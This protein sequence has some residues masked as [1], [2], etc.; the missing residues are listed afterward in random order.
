MTGFPGQAG[1]FGRYRILRRIGYGGM[2][3]VFEAAQDGLGRNVALKVLLPQLSDAPEFRARF[4][5]EARTLAALDSPHVIQVYEYGEEDGQLYIATQLVKGSDLQQL[6]ESKGP[7]TLVRS[8]E[9]VAQLASGLA[10]AHAAGLLH[11]DVKP[12][13]VL[14]RESLDDTH[15]YLCDFGI[16]RD[17]DDAHLTSTGVAGTV[18]Y[19]APE[20]HSGVEAT[21]ASDVYS[22][23]CVLW[24]MITGRAPYA[25]HSGVQLALA[26]MH[27]PLPALDDASA[28][29]TVVNRVL[30]RSM[31]KD[32]VDRYGSALEMRRDLQAALDV[33]KAQEA[34][35]NGEET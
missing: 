18:G 17:E 23:G 30:T 25:G 21:A 22:L 14:L 33:A 11:R 28:A 19:M 13:N 27:E 34:G 7:A 31:A 4:E 35:A 32:P 12:S 1:V 3:T 16:A 6:I 26:H 8:L 24:A 15:A 20:R 5:R 29:G 10:D 2:G 9:V